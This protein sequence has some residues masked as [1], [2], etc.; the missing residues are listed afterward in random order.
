[1]C[2]WNRSRLS[3]FG[4][5]EGCF[6]LRQPGFKSGKPAFQIAGAA[7]RDNRKNERG[8]ENRQADKHQKANQGIII[9][10]IRVYAKAGAGRQCLGIRLRRQEIDLVLG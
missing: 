10:G 6:A 7:Q 5:H 4:C 2:Q 8:E 9:H 3:G 1:M